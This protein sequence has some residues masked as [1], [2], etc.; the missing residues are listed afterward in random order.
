M[1]HCVK[2]FGGGAAKIAIS[3]S[4]TDIW[5]T[6]SRKKDGWGRPFWLVWERILLFRITA[7]LGD[8]L[9]A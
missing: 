2:N 8:R 6:A 9:R 3:G 7:D 1:A 4:R 5:S